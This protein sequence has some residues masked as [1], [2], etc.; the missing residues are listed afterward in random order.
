MT[1]ETLSRKTKAMNLKWKVPLQIA[2]P[3]L[4]IVLA[5]SAF[6]YWQ[7]ARALEERRSAVLEAVMEE[8]Q[9]ALREWLAQIETDIILMAEFDSTGDALNRFTRSRRLVGENPDETLRQLYIDENPNPVGA[10][11]ELMT[12]RDGSLWSEAHALFHPD[13]RRFQQMRD[14]NDLFLFDPD[15]NLVYSVVKGP[16]FATNFVTGPYADSALGR[17]FREAL[18]LEAVDA[19]FSEI[20]AYAP[21]DGLP[22]KFVA[23]PVLNAEGV[24]LGVA[25]LQIRV[26]EVGTILGQTPF[27]GRTGL[28][29]A[30][31]GE[32]LALTASQHPGGHGILDPLP[33]LP[34]VIATRQNETFFSDDVTGLSGNPALALADSFEVNGTDWHIVMEQ[35]REE[36]MATE[37]GLFVTTVAQVLIVLVM[38]MGVAIVVARMLTGRIGDL[39]QSVRRIADGD[40]HTE[41][42]QAGTTDEIGDIAR[43][44]NGF[45]EDLSQ[46]EAAHAREQQK[47]AQ[48]AKAMEALREALVKLADGNLDCAIRQTLDGDYAPLKEHFNATA[49][50][51]SAIIEELR[52]SAISMETDIDR[53]GEGAEQLSSRTENQAATLE[54]TAAAMD[55]ISASVN[56]TARGA[57][58]IVGAIGVAR[59]QAERGEEVRGRAVHAMSAIES[60]SKQIAQIIGVIEDIAFQTNLLSLNAGVEAARA[61]EVGRGFAVVASEVRALA[62]RSSDSASEIRSLIT[63]S[64]ENVSNGVRLVSELGTAME[65]I[66]HE[67]VS[68]SERVQHI[69]VGAAEQAQGIGEINNGISMLDQVTQQNAA[70]VQES[71]ASGRG[72][73]DKAVGLR[74]LVARFRTQ[75]TPGT[76][77]RPVAR[78]AGPAAAVSEKAPAPKRAAQKTQ[79]RAAR[80]AASGGGHADTADLGWDSADARPLPAKSASPV[81]AAAGGAA[82][83]WQDF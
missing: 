11:D 38:V 19:V 61:G 8:R 14:Y 77:P 9:V 70:M 36:A 57:K 56:S 22:A 71:V 50:S 26:E 82:P 4:A 63:N 62:Q 75:G 33:D 39:L 69:A 52:S 37:N 59:D 83:L 23:A 10:K 18:A 21:R 6:A 42:A 53:L 81:R 35:D 15:G 1:S 43:A 29:Y 20:E 68:V 72:L 60:S 51:L 76:K 31:N 55:Q 34:Q 78:D 13:L 74:S 65:G 45:R 48:Q 17:V 27:L 64:S 54:E 80:P 3:T 28:I 7:A 25:A 44:L 40:Y 32:G 41:V 49:E 16:E 58:E 46:V 67:V 73:K 2:M 5:V 24:L 47:A 12:A 66:L 79:P 30:V